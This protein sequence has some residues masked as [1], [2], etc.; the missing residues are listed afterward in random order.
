MAAVR[1]GKADAAVEPRIIDPKVPTTAAEKGAE[2]ARRLLAG[3]IT[4]RSGG[5][6]VGKITPKEL[7]PAIVIGECTADACNVR[8]NAEKLAKAIGTDVKKLEREPVDASWKVSGKTA[9]VIPA[10]NG[11]AL[12]PIDTA[13]L[14]RNAGLVAAERRPHRGGRAARHRARDDDGQGQ[15]VGHQAADEHRHHRPRAPRPPNRIHNVKLLASILDGKIVPPGGTFSFNEY[16]GAAHAG[17]RLQGGLRDRRRPAS[18]RP[19]AAASAR[20]PRRSSTPPSTPACPS[21]SARTTRSTS[22]TTGWAWTRRSTGPAP[23]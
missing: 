1:A 22:R 8:V 20:R 13:R 19:S 4:L 2:E 7:A 14:V 17:A 6:S 12:H 21:S 3:P 15:V 9:R 23:T 5:K 18:C 11:L 10:K 16:V